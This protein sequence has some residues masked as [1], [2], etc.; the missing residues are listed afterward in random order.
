MLLVGFLASPLALLTPLPIKIAIDSVIG[1]QPLPRYL[2]RLLPETAGDGAIL[3]LAVGLLLVV[4]LLSQVQNVGETV[5]RTYAGERL[6]L[7]FR[8]ELFRYMQRL[9]F[10][11]SDTRGAADTLYRIQ[12][13]APA[14]RWVIIDGVI[15]FIT[16]AVSASA[17][18]IVAARIDLQLAMVALVVSPPM[19][20]AFGAF[21]RRLRRRSKTIK[22]IESSALSVVHEVLAAFRVVKAFGQEEREQ[23]RFIQRSREGADGRV[24][25]AL[26]EGV[27]GLV[28]A[29]ITA[30][31]TAAVLYI[32]VSHVQQGLLT[33]GDLLLVLGYLTQL[34]RPLQTMSGKVARLQNHLASAERAFSL[35]DQAPDVAERPSARPLRRAKGRVSFR[36]VSF[37]YQ[38]D[39]PVIEHVTFEIPAGSIVGLAG[40]T[41]AGKTTLMSLLTR[42][43]DPNEGEIMLDGI[44]LRDIKLVDLRSQFAIVLQEPVLFSTTI[45][46]NIAYGRPGAS[47]RDVARAAE[48]AGA[49]N[50]ISRLPDGYDTQVGERGV[51]LS[52][53]ERQRIA[54]ARAF[55]KDAPILILDEP[56]SSVDLN[57]EGAIL[58]S[59]ADLM[60]GRTTFM[61]SHRPSALELCDMLVEVEGGAVVPV[62]ESRPTATTIRPAIRL[63]HPA[64]RA[65]RALASAGSAP[66][67]IEHVVRP[68]RKRQVYR[69]NEA[70]PQGSPLVA[71]RSPASTAR[72]ERLIYEQAL[73]NIGVSAP[74]YGGSQDGGDDTAWIFLEDVSATS[75]PFSSEDPSHRAAASI[76]LGELHVAAAGLDLASVLPEAGLARY[77]EHLHSARS[78]IR[79]NWN[80][81]ALELND[82]VILRRILSRLDEIEGCWPL[83]EG[84]CEGAPSTLVHADFQ[85]KN[86]FVQQGGDH[87]RL[88]PIDW[89]VAGW[90]LTAVDLS[91]A[92]GW[93]PRIDLG[94]YTSIVKD[95]WQALDLSRVEQLMVVGGLLQRLAAVDWA[96]SHLHHSWPQNATASLRLYEPEL[97]EA[98]SMIRREWGAAKYG[99]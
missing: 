72:V 28:I 21:R 92:T 33:L 74:H 54:L 85:R 59:L 80:N 61:I 91:P 15:P 17:M 45:A 38:K 39:R 10:S 84:L 87:L 64:E 8:S 36:D 16:A 34:Y 2:G 67:H 97:T 60:R 44:D 90:G 89:E 69:L 6:V 77:L 95:R 40:P 50:F 30:C 7:R 93:R 94:I 26:I 18:V 56:T 12:Y 1:D 70:G 14:I 27:F 75:E 96:C 13:D 65:W 86:L 46:E 22:G 52:G 25:L 83:V 98:I 42:F 79:E 37:G 55:L 99:E 53:G 66:A 32:G 47:R 51:L 23:D 81:P 11:Y 82:L 20:G 73:P 24:R 49:E 58:D 19:L 4:T 35:L 88:L 71:K 76:W 68:T 9:S 31:G 29:L 57:T 62:V 5:L 43:Y 48:A 63:E 3:S 41:G 78:R